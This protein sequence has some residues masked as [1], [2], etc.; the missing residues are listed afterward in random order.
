MPLLKNLSKRFRENPELFERVG[1]AVAWATSGD[2]LK[3]Y[4][5]LWFDSGR[6][7]DEFERRLW[8]MRAALL[9]CFVYSP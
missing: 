4:Q 8:S 3:L 7:N 6:P 1:I 5:E 9:D 2:Q